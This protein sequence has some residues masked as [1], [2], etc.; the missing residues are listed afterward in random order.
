MIKS[1]VSRLFIEAT[2]MNKLKLLVSIG[3]LCVNLIETSESFLEQ[4]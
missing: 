4:K 2:F 1:S 3:Y